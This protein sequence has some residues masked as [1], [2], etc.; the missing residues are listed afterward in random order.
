M[1]NM[2]MVSQTRPDIRPGAVDPW[3]KTVFSGE[4][5]SVQN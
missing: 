2:V 3:L 4:K 1:V 5:Y